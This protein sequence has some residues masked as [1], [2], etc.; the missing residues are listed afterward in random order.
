MAVGSHFLDLQDLR[1]QIERI[2]NHHDDHPLLP[3]S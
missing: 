3:I 1:V 2:D